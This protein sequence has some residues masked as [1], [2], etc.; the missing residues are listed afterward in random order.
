MTQNNLGEAYR[1]RIRG[2][3]AEN[4]EQ[5]ITAYTA[6]LQIRTR[7]DF[8]QDWAMTQ[9]N[10]GIAYSNRIRGDQAENL[11]QAITAY[12]AALE[13]STRA[14][15]PQNWAGTQNN[16]GIAY[17]DRIRGDQAENLELA[18]AAFSAALQIRTRADF[19]QDWA[20]TQNN[21]GIAYSNRIRGD[22]AENL[23]QAITA[24]SAAL[25]IPTRADFP[26]NWAGTQNNLGI[27]YSN[28]IRGDKAENLEL[29]IAAF[30]AAL[31]I[32]T[33]ADFPQN[34]A[35]TLFNLG[36]L[37][38]D[39][40]QFTLAESTF[41]AA[42]E[43][44]ENLRSD[45]VSG[46]ESKRKQAEQWNQL[47]RRMVEVCLALGKEPEAIQY[48]ERSKTRN[49]VELISANPQFTPIKYLEIQNLLDNET[50]IIQLYIFTDSFRAFIITNTED[51][52]L[53]W[54]SSSDD[55]AKLQT[56]IINYLQLYD[57][58]K[59]QW[60]DELNN[61]LLELGKILQMEH[62]ISL[63]PPHC[64]KV[65]F[66]PHRY[67][68]LLP[69][70]ALVVRESY[71][72]DLFPK[73]VG[74][75]PSCQLLQQ[76]HHHQR[77]D[78]ESLF[79][80]Q[81]P[82]EDLNEK[83]LGAITA[84]KQTFEYPRI[85]KN[86]QAKKSAIFS[87][88]QITSADLL[89]ANSVLFFCHGNFEFTSPWNSGLQLADESLTLADIIN[90]LK[91]DNCRLVTLAACETGLIDPTNTSDEYIGLPSGLFLAGSTNVVSSLWVVKAKVTA[92]LMIKFYQELQEQNNIVLA[93]NTA[94]RWLRDTTA[95]GFLNWLSNSSLTLG[96]QTR[97]SRYFAKIAT[98]EGED[99]KPFA[100]PYYWSAFCAIGKGD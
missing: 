60:Q 86:K 56:W 68:H 6:A 40:N 24:F 10:L 54:Q 50:V 69:L 64:Q 100:S 2:D 43:T 55:L 81:T 32:R 65:I 52:P 18:I 14:D 37:Y 74:Y 49:L 51:K 83:D 4:L 25:Q 15:F 63:V 23:E 29:A 89:K 99:V 12:S 38:Q 3:K 58:N 66:I 62:I 42:I 77:H 59:K 30:S 17:S 84:I 94:Q 95:K 73:G 22:Q 93:L 87:T 92:L 61:Q 67:L 8:P 85:L 46:E 78:F 98:D 96:W 47:F 27:A 45:I 41:A 34:H 1:N 7:A 90:H 20:M 19:P 76:V 97:L 11:E 48:I 26:Q 79:A 80:I 16:L 72:L 57:T 35:E 39:S 33:R 70:H 9:N 88:E 5:A 36:I 75:A 28:R 21:L 31:Q 82:T 91:L 71:L 44:V 13:I 53:V